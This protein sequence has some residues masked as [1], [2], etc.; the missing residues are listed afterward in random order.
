MKK[1]NVN[2][3][4]LG[5]TPTCFESQAFLAQ[6]KVNFWVMKKRGGQVPFLKFELPL[7]SCMIL[8]YVLRGKLVHTSKWN[9]VQIFVVQWFV[10]TSPAH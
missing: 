5:S 1:F 7:Q 8:T 9:G 3:Y 6:M 2:Y 10:P 4:Y